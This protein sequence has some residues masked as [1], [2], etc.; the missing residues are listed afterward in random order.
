MAQSNRACARL[1][2]DGCCKSLPAILLCHATVGL[3]PFL[4]Y[5]TCPECLVRC[6]AGERKF[7]VGDWVMV[8][9]KGNRAGKKYL[10]RVVATKV[11][12]RGSGVKTPMGGAE[13]GHCYYLYSIKYHGMP[14]TDDWEVQ[15]LLSP[16]SPEMIRKAIEPG[17]SGVQLAGRTTPQMYA[18][19]AAHQRLSFARSLLPAV[20]TTAVLGAGGDVHE[21]VGRI[22]LQAAQTA[23]REPGWSVRNPGAPLGERLAQTLRL[24]LE[25]EDQQPRP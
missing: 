3:F 13:E 20:E 16:A 8:R 12:W 23:A 17:A 10:G 18:F 5:F 9:R 2:F 1:C 15:S 24:R 21:L 14:Q 4:C 7:Q 19:I 6:S 25:A 11:G 22:L